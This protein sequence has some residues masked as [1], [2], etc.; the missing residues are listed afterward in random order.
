[1][2]GSVTLRVI[3]YVSLAIGIGI[4]TRPA[5]G[6][7]VFGV[8]A[9]LDAIFFVRRGQPP[10]DEERLEADTTPVTVTHPE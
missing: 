5:W 8:L 2:N 3:A 10:Q 7:I 6:F 4:L 1:M 9:L